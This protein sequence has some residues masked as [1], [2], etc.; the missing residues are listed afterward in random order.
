MKAKTKMDPERKV[1][2]M[3]SGELLAFSVL[4]LVLGSLFVADVISVAD[5]KRWVFSILTFVGGLW[6]MIDFVWTLVSKKRRAKQCLLDK[7]MVFPM[8]LAVFVFDLIAFIS[9]W[10]QTEEGLVYF[11]FAIGI[12]L[13]YYGVIYVFQGFYHYKHP[14]PMLLEAIEE[15]KREEVKKNQPVEETVKEEEPS[16]EQ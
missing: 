5:W 9:G 6:L 8:A 7:I 1:K 15:E 12:A 2:L 3:Y 14:V 13:L 16:N 11:R 10:L 4:F